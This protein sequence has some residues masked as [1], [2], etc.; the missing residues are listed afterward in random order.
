MSTQS[1]PLI[2][3]SAVIDT[4]AANNLTGVLFSGVINM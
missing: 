1:E 3:E 2:G 4:H